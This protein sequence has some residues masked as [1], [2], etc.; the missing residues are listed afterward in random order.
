VNIKIE[1]PNGLVTDLDTATVKQDV[2]SCAVH[3]VVVLSMTYDVIIDNGV[4]T[5]V[6]KS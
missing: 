3:N 4:V 6:E 1:W 5:F 2:V